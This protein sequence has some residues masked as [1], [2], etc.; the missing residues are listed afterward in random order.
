MFVIRLDANHQKGMGHLF[1]MLHV[2]ENLTRNKDSIL[3]AGRLNSASQDI[4]REKGY[5]FSAFGPGCDENEII[6]KIFTDQ[7]GIALWIYDILDTESLWIEAIRGHKVRVLCMDDN[8]AGVKLADQVILTLPTK[9]LP[10]T[11]RDP[12]GRILQGIEYM[13]LCDNAHRLKKARTILRDQKIRL[14]ICMGGSD[15]YGSSIFLA[16]VLETVRDRLEEVHFFLG[17][18][19]EHEQRLFEQLADVSYVYQCHSF[20]QNLPVELDA[21]DAVIS[22]GGMTLFEAAS[23]G[24]PILAFANELFEL[25]NIQYLAERGAC[26]LLGCIH[27]RAFDQVQF[28]LKR[29]LCSEVQLTRMAA[30]ARR[31]VV[32]DGVRRIAEVIQYSA[33]PAYS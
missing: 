17:P 8:G 11:E 32:Q 5:P 14:G 20:V 25:A 22:G 29:L 15:T 31:V 4:L 16:T 28:R 9:Y 27:D 1:R 30:K 7:S 23:M 18:S 26:A 19:F 24:L 6:E 10:L 12:S 3:F 2:A 33:F 13:I 21:L